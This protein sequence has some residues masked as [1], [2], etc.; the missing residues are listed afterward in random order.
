[1][2]LCI[3]VCLYVCYFN[4]L[5]LLVRRRRSF[6]AECSTIFLNYTGSARLGHVVLVN[7]NHRLITIQI[8]HYMSSFHAALNYK[9]EK[10]H[11]RKSYGPLPQVYCERKTPKY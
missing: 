8:E 1:M 3:F 11:V 10:D 9:T 2:N 4:P 7:F 6:P 5:N